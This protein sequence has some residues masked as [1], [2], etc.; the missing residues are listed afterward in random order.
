MVFSTVLFGLMAVCIRLASK[1]QHAFEI[2]FFRNLFG[3]V[4]TLPLLWQHGLGI[5]KTEKLPLYLFRCFIGTIGMM[6][7][8]WA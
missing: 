7:G 3:L 1:Q 8:F 5:L 2:A 4:F 6:S